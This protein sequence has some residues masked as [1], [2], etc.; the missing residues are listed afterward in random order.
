MKKKSY[1]PI[2]HDALRD[3]ASLEAASSPPGLH[4]VQTLQLNAQKIFIFCPQP[5]FIAIIEQIASSIMLTHLLTERNMY[6]M[7]QFFLIYI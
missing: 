3:D 5:L 7:I 6:K 1:L 4:C 2:S